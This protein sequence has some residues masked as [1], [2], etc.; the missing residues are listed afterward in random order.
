MMF[1]CMHHVKK[2][3]YLWFFHGTLGRT[4]PQIRQMAEDSMLK[5]V[6]W[7]GYSKV[8]QKRLDIVKVALKD[9]WARD[10]E[11]VT[12]IMNELGR[13]ASIGDWTD[14]AKRHQALESITVDDI[15]N[16]AKSVF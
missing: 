11:S 10:T 7:F 15:Q 2:N 4:S 3:N 5:T 13:S 12:D 1:L 16:I 8:S 6:Q 9:G 14:Y